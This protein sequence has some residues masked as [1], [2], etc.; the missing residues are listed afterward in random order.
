MSTHSIEIADRPSRRPGRGAVIMT[1]VA[2]LVFLAGC[3]ERGD[4]GI[5]ASIEREEKIE[6]SNLPE[7]STAGS[8]VYHAG[9]DRYYVA[10]GQLYA[11]DRGDNDWDDVN[12]PGGYGD[13][14]TLDIVTMG[15]D[16][17]VAFFDTESTKSE[18][19]RLNP[20]ND[21]YTSVWSPG[22][23]IAKLI[24]IDTD[25]A[26]EASEDLNEE[27]FAV[28]VESNKL[29]YNLVYAPGNTGDTQNTVLSDVPRIFDG[30]Y[31]F[32]V[33]GGQY[34]FVAGGTLFAG[35]DVTQGSADIAEVAGSD[36]PFATFGGT[37]FVEDAFG[38]AANDWLYVTSTRGDIAY[39][40][41][42]GTWTWT[43]E[44]GDDDRGYTD[45]TYL[46]SADFPGLSGSNGALV[47]GVDTRETSP[48]GYYEVS[49]SL[50]TSRPDSENYDAADVSD[51]AINGFYVD[52]A[53]QTLFALT[54]GTGLWRGNYDTAEAD[55]SWE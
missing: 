41:D 14:H 23:E 4:V 51:A 19:F 26:D 13:G 2:V 36:R 47:V 33:A 24:A 38:N 49:E 45:I 29:D 35:T 48:G 27:L 25:G 40:A 31:D 52:A 7:V 20:T 53:N 32:V 12:H 28:T 34:L 16:I 44:T 54:S 42:A 3:G 30:A 9:T 55:W 43:T 37:T 10:L 5:F 21:N 46:D 39:T 22:D 11:R 1:A 50:G 8:V 6:K 15:G 17:Y 18:I